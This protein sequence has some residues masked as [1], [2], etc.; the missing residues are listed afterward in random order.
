MTQDGLMHTTEYQA[1]I[2]TDYKSQTHLYEHAYDM[3]SRLYLNVI[4][5]RV[6]AHAVE[7]SVGAT[8]TSWAATA[9]PRHISRQGMGDT[10]G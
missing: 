3:Q 9:G 8:W 10:E 1:R 2:S 7:Q 6:L 4:L 5:H